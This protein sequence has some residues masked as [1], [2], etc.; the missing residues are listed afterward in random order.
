VKTYT[1]PAEAADRMLGYSPIIQITKDSIW[2]AS[3]PSILKAAQSDG[4]KLKDGAAFKKTMA[5]L[6]Q[7]GNSLAYI[8]ED[9]IAELVAQY[10]SADKA[11]HLDDPDFQAAKP[12]VDKLIADL[13][14]PGSGIAAVIDVDQNGMNSVLRVPFPTK[15]YLTQLTPMFQSAVAAPLIMRQIKKNE[16][17]EHR[18]R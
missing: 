11:G 15:N 13:T 8:S 3:K 1:L 12:L 16:D 4:K 6:P 17:Q 14:K 10:K 9:F 2:L 7:S 18:F 5:T